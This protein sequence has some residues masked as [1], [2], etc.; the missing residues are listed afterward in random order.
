MIGWY[1]DLGVC[2]RAMGIERVG[3]GDEIGWWSEKGE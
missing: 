1:E 3:I 2:G